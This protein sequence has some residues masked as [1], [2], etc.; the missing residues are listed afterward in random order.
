MT[1]SMQ[2]AP[3]LGAQRNSGFLRL[4]LKG[5][6]GNPAGNFRVSI[7]VDVVCRS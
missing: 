7:S 6:M 5:T 3:S 2:R 4:V 1:R